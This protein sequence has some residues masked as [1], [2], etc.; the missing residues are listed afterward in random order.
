MKR[1]S[2][3]ILL[4]LTSL[5]S[6]AQYINV[7][8]Y[9]DPGTDLIPRERYTA[10]KLD[11]SIRNG[12]YRLYSQEG[13]VLEE[14]SYFEGLPVGKRMIRS[15]DGLL[16]LVGYYKANGD[17]LLI[18]FNY[19]NMRFNSLEIERNQHK[20][21]DRVK[22]PAFYQ[23]AYDSLQN[24]L[25]R[26]NVQDDSLLSNYI[27]KNDLTG[28]LAVIKGETREVSSQYRDFLIYKLYSLTENYPSIRE[29]N[30]QI[31]L[32]A[33][34]IED[35][36]KKGGS[37]TYIKV[38]QSMAAEIK[39]YFHTDSIEYLFTYGNQLKR[40][41]KE[42]EPI[43][44]D[45]AETDQAIRKNKKFLV[46]TFRVNPRFSAIYQKWILPL[47]DSITWYYEKTDYIGLK[48]E[49]GIKLNR[50]ISPYINFYPE[51][52]LKDSLVLF[53]PRRLQKIFDS[54]YPGKFTK[55][56]AD[57]AYLT[58]TYDTINYIFKKRFFADS[59]L[60][61]INKLNA[62]FKEL[63]VQSKYFKDRFKIITDYYQSNQQ[64]IYAGEIVPL[65][66]MILNLQNEKDLG[67]RIE[68]GEEIKK[69]IKFLR[70]TIDS[71]TK[72]DTLVETRYRWVQTKY[73]NSFK[74][75]Y[76]DEIMTDENKLNDYR[77]SGKTVVKLNRGQEFLY[78]LSKQDSQFEELQTQNLTI[79][80][81]LEKG[82]QTYSNDF[83]NIR[84]NEIQMLEN[85][86]ARYRDLTRIDPR[87]NTGQYII[88]QLQY[89]VSCF[90]T[91]VRQDTAIKRMLPLVMKLYKEDFP[92]IYE[93]DLTAIGLQTAS[94]SEMTN[95][96][97]MVQL[98]KEIDGKLRV[99]LAEYPEIK[100]QQEEILADYQT[101]KNNF[102]N[103][104]KKKVIFKKGT[105]AVDYIYMNYKQE[106]S[107]VLVTAKGKELLSLIKTMN[108]YLDIDTD[109]LVKKLNEVSEPEEI[110]RVFIR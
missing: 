55:D 23:L 87:L 100:T 80:Q 56:F 24:A 101:F 3:L 69:K 79:S 76:L 15:S 9:Y 39:T 30:R 34:K 86:F 33:R 94:L 88:N 27:R 18:K 59:I 25:K 103:N 95:V 1:Y 22:G 102:S 65:E 78:L 105:K 89:I 71:I 41:L 73:R 93:S 77:N 11:P 81:L 110:K 58:A 44:G 49:M 45:A 70:N 10:F 37:V 6:R 50:N 7:T 98:G 66:G 48:M 14:S 47:V 35:K 74:G 109:Y 4:V 29:N 38:F 68:Q 52:K 85:S 57:I 28:E 53:E 20:V 84:K 67:T 5:F 8:T 12:Q 40:E 82:N 13:M 75:I 90:D 16:K 104:K 97:K 46:D 26:Y 42:K 2:T 106:R 91:L 21:I 72:Y 107:V 51:M 96:K 32:K 83:T 31:G 54:V 63:E 92:G 36:I 99:Y 64:A 17:Y 60:E 61:R 19:K 62:D 108:T 43:L